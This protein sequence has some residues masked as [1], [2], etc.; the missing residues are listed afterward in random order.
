MQDVVPA[1]RRVPGTSRNERTYDY[2]AL[3]RLTSAIESGAT[4]NSYGYPK[5]TLVTA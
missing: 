5:T 4:S 3:Q 2:D 1:R